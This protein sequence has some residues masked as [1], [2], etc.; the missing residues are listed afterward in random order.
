MRPSAERDSTN[1]EYYEEHVVAC[2]LA[3]TEENFIKTETYTHEERKTKCD[4]YLIDFRGPTE[5]LD[6]LYVKFSFFGGWVALHS[7][8]LQR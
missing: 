6:R 1:L 8:H 2:C 4:V 5:S 3:L 7:F